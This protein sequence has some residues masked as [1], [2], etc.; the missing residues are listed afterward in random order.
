MKLTKFKQCVKLYQKCWK[1]QNDYV[2]MRKVKRTNLIREIEEIKEKF[3]NTNKDDVNKYVRECPEDFRFRSL[4]YLEN[5]KTGFTLTRKTA[6]KTKE[7]D[8]RSF[9][10]IGNNQGYCD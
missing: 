9:F 4:R 6:T 8:I 1:Q 5:W 3:H 7:T 10:E 2:Q